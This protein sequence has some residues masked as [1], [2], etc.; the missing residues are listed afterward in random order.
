M[1]ASTYQSILDDESSS[2]QNALQLPNTSS[3]DNFYLSFRYHG[4]RPIVG[5]FSGKEDASGIVT[6]K[7][8][9]LDKTNKSVDG[10]NPKYQGNFAGSLSFGYR[11]KNFRFELEGLHSEI[12]TENTYVELHRDPPHLSHN[13]K[14]QPIHWYIKDSNQAID[15]D[16]YSNQYNYNKY[17][18]LSAEKI[19][20]ELQA[21]F[22]MTNYGFKNNAALL[23]AYYDFNNAS[24]FTPF[25]GF[26]A[27][28]T[29][30]KFLSASCIKPA[31]QAKAGLSYNITPEIQLSAGYRYFSVVGDKFVVKPDLGKEIPELYYKVGNNNEKFEYSASTTATVKNDLSSHAIEVGLTFN[32]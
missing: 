26:G 7:I 14:D 8:V 4:E 12:K 17:P 25:I 15:K 21:G 11:I 9:S 1:V 6:E 28:L 18:W 3:Q 10:Y 27:G 23:N 24:N 13:Q 32:F 29:N 31:Y 19:N 30:I 5:T 20:G 16:H 2:S 22:K